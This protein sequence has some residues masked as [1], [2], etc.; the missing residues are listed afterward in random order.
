MHASRQLRVQGLVA[1]LVRAVRP[2]LDGDLGA[3]PAGGRQLERVDQVAHQLRLARRAQHL[4]KD[5][6]L[7]FARFFYL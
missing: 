2:V 5:F 4:R 6:I 7:R 3:R 1:H